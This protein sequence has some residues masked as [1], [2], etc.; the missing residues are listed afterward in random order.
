M[1]RRPGRRPDRGLDLETDPDPGLSGL[2]GP[3]REWEL[4]RHRAYQAAVGGRCIGDT[5]RQA[6]GRLTETAGISQGHGP[7]TA[8]TP[9]A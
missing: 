4:T 9:Y 5:F 1:R 3:A 2:S 8:G 6:A 7:V